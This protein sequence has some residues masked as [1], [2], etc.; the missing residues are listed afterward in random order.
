MVRY[1]AFLEVADDGL[2]MAHILALPGCIARAPT[3][4]EALHQLPHVIRAYHDWLRRHGEAA[5]PLDEPVEIAIADMSTGF[6]PFNPGDAAALFAPDRQPITPDEIDDHLRLMSY[7]RADLLALV[8]TRPDQILDWQLD[9]QSF[10]IRRLLRHIGNAEEWYVS[11]IAPPETLPPEW[12][13]DEDMP[14]MDFLEME[15]RTAG[16]RLR[17]LTE[18]ERSQVFHPQR[19]T[20]HP[21][22]L[23]TARKAM[24]RCLEHEREHTAQIGQILALY[25]GK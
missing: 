15:R 8:R 11:R 12:E 18:A 25:Q 2:C 9:A 24:R 16:A 3:Q 17:Q 1:S 7:S 23:W 20:R 14:V 13:H 21:E 22:E 19:G 4:T 10:P 6:G 5:P